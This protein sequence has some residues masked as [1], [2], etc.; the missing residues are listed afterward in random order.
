VP[1]FATIKHLEP[2]KPDDT[3]HPGSQEDNYVNEV[4]EK[5]PLLKG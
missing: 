2:F 1:L 5:L 3:K 4:L